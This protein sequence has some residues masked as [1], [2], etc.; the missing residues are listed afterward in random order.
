MASTVALANI[1]KGRE[2]RISAEIL[3]QKLGP[4]QPPAVEGAYARVACFLEKVGAISSSSGLFRAFPG[5]SSQ[6]NLGASRS[7][8]LHSQMGMCQNWGSPQHV[9]LQSF[10]FS[11]QSWGARDQ[12]VF[13]PPN[14]SPLFSVLPARAAPPRLVE[15][16][17]LDPRPGPRPGLDAPGSR[18]P[19]RHGWRAPAPILPGQNQWG[20]CPKHGPKGET[21]EGLIIFFSW[22]LQVAILSMLGWARNEAGPEHR[23]FCVCCGFQWANRTWHRSID[24]PGWH[25]KLFEKERERA[26]EDRRTRAFLRFPSPLAHSRS[27]SWT[28]VTFW[29]W[30]VLEVNSKLRL[31]WANPSQEVSCS[32]LPWHP[33]VEFPWQ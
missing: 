2:L 3:D 12:S 8:S 31:V 30:T 27:G 26:V 16:S 23:I 11:C 21:R 32:S 33:L 22:G 24:L 5:F 28:L 4:E 6:K 29:V 17:R 7:P 25:P 14:F 20:G 10:V 1:P 9:K 19:P 15:M 18:A 13:P